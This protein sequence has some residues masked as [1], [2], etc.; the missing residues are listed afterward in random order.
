MKPIDWRKIDGQW[1]LLC[2][3]KV[4]NGLQV[5]MTETESGQMDPLRQVKGMG[6]HPNHTT[7][8][9]K[10]AYPKPLQPSNAADLW[11]RILAVFG[12][13]PREAIERNGRVF[14]MPF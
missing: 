5:N 4:S 11:S 13:M 9:C 3:D 10:Y 14:P 6:L 7:C 12:A 1:S 2:V 8:K